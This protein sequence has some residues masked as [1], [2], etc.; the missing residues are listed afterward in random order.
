M[1]GSVAE[2]KSSSCARAGA[3]RLQRSIMPSTEW[4]S[5][6]ASRW[7]PVSAASA[8]TISVSRDSHSARQRPSTSMRWASGA[9]AHA[10]CAARN[11][12]NIAVSVAAE[13]ASKQ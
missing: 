11:P 1:V 13:G 8:A 9:A 6:T 12:M 5:L 7:R 10:G 3:T 2:R 4:N